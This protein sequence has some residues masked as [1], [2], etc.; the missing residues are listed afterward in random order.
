MSGN[1][2]IHSIR[3]L[4]NTEEQ[5]RRPSPFNELRQQMSDVLGDGGI[6]KE[7]VQA[8]DGPPVPYNA[9]VLM[10]Y[11]GY[12]EYSNV[13][14]ETNTYQRFPKIMKL[15]RD[16]TLTGLEMGLLTMKKGEFS[17]FLF[18]PQYAYGDLG[19][20]PLIP[21]FSVVLYE[22]HILDF[23]DSGQVDD[24]TA[25]SQD[26]Q[27]TAPLSNLLEVVNT[28]RSFG[29]RCFNQSRYH[30]AKDHYKEAVAL[31][32][33]REKQSDVEREK[34]NKALLPLYLNLSVTELQP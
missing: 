12:L 4:L 34:L 15:G 5:L 2:L 22:V 20:P 11:S 6:L 19:C 30:D 9:S 7:L 14:F 32:G 21:A 1:G 24:F 27:N 26:E 8:G 29:N 18:E 10:H 13:P 16:V 28:V 25:M 17:R 3:R 23:L 31:L 33:N